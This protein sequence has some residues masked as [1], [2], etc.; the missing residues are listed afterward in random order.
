MEEIQPDSRCGNRSVPAC[1][2]KATRGTRA[3]SV[4]AMRA[5]SG[6]GAQQR[7]QHVR[8]GE[9]R[10]NPEHSLRGS[11][12]RIVGPRQ[13]TGAHRA[14]GLIR[15]ADRLPIARRK[16]CPTPT[17]NAHKP[18]RD[19]CPVCAGGQKG[20]LNYFTL[21]ICQLSPG[22]I[23]RRTTVVNAMPFPRREELK[24]RAEACR[25]VPSFQERVSP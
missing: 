10:G 4:L 9:H 20:R 11:L 21:V 15:M 6:R 14:A 22:A 1:Y 17:P 12:L 13:Y 2:G 25:F 8:V 7:R 3:G 16:P 19:R 24:Q 18:R 23:R 5:R